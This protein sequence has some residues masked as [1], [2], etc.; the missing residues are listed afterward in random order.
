MTE[1]EKWKNK[2]DTYRQQIISLYPAV[3]KQL[4]NAGMKA[5]LEKSLRRIKEKLPAE[6]RKGADKAIMEDINDVMIDTIKNLT[7]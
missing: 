5:G 7:R 1:F 2:H 6:L 3:A 4:F